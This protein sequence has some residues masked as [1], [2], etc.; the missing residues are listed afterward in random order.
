MSTIERVRPATR[1]PKAAALGALSFLIVALFVTIASDV[2]GVVYTQGQTVESLAGFE[3]ALPA[4]GAAVP[5]EL[6]RLI[7]MAAG[8]FLSFWLILPPQSGQRVAGVVARSLV[9]VAVGL[10][11]AMAIAAVRLVSSDLPVS[12][13]AGGPTDNRY[14]LLV[15]GGLTNDAWQLFTQ[16]FALVV[17]VGLAMWG[18]RLTRTAPER[19]VPADAASTERATV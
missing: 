15:F 9:A 11:F 18:A 19:T 7:P 5:Y 6:W 12:P 2:V 1:H 16:T 3:Y 10:V 8:V 13:N 4:L 14:Y 17:A